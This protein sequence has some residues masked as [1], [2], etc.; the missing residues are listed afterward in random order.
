MTICIFHKPEQSVFQ[1]FRLR[2]VLW[3][4]APSPGLTRL[5]ISPHPFSPDHLAVSHTSI[6]L[7][8]GIIQIFTISSKTLV[9][10]HP[11]TLDLC[12]SSLSHIFNQK[13]QLQMPT[14]DGGHRAGIKAWQRQAASGRGFENWLAWDPGQEGEGLLCFLLLNFSFF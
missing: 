5:S 2:W 14:P 9:E 12:Q 7:H 8:P 3:F 6:V 11:S 13:T 1:C 10:S 4:Y